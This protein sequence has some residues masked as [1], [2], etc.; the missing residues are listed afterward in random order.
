M[1]IDN[2]SVIKNGNFAQH[3]L[4]LGRKDEATKFLNNT[5]ILN[6]DKKRPLLIELW[7]YRYAHYYDEFPE[8]ETKIKQLLDEGVKSIGWILED[9]VTKAI[10]DGHPEPEKL[11]AL[12][13]QI[14]TD[15]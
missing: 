7:F 15:V 11:K 2:K 9:N 5:F 1:Q 10:A 14:T 8:A 4:I 13:K 3:L 6:N 12:A